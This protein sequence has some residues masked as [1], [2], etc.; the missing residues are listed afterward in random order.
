M[1][2]I[3]DIQ[4]D[5]DNGMFYKICS[6]ETTFLNYIKEKLITFKKYGKK[7]I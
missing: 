5:L 7:K 3:Q 4:K 1:D 6:N 2:I